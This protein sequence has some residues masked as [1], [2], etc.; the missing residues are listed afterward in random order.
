MVRT[1]LYFEMSCINSPLRERGTQFK[2]PHD[3]LGFHIPDPIYWVR[4]L[5]FSFLNHTVLSI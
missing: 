4:L 1:A 3:I 2:I 5:P